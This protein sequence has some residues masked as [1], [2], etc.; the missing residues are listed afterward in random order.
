MITLTQNNLIFLGYVIAVIVGL[1]WLRR[2]LRNEAP[3]FFTNLTYDELFAILDVTIQR[4]IMEYD[5]I[6]RLKDVRVIY[7]LEEDMRKLTLAALI[8]ISPEVR[9]SINLYHDDDYVDTYVAR[10][11]RQYLIEYTRQNKI[12]SK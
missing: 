4:E 1:L 12:S 6:A 5:R 7:D 2:S 8:H 11:V 3:V 10:Y 9:K